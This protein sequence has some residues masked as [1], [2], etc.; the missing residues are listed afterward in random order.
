MKTHE[1]HTQTHTSTPHQPT[2]AKPFFGTQPDQ[3]F[4]ST[5]RAPATPFFQ[6]PAATNS[7]IQAKGATEEA[8]L[9]EPVVQRMPAFASEI[10][11][12]GAVQRSPW[13]SPPSLGSPIQ[14]KLTIGPVGDRYEQ[15]A[16]RVA[17]QVVEQIHA[18]AAAQSTPGQAV[19][20]Q[21]EEP[22]ELQAKPEITAL[23]RMEEKPEELQAKPE[24]TTIQ[25]MEEKPEELQAK[26]EITALQRMEEKPEE[27]QAKPEITALQRM[28]EKPEELQA[29]PEI[30]T[31]QRMEE[32]P[33]ELQAKSI[34][35]RQG[36]TSGEAAPD[37]TAAIDIARGSGQPLDMDLQRSIGQA[38]GADFSGVKVHTDAQSDQLNR[39]LQAKAFTTGQDVFFRQGAYEP[40]S[41]GGQELIA[42]ELTHVV[43]QNG[44]A[45]QQSPVLLQPLSRGRVSLQRKPVEDPKR[46][47]PFF[48]D[49][50]KPELKLKLTKDEESKKDFQIRNQLQPIYW[51]EETEDN[52]YKDVGRTEFFDVDA[53]LS[54]HRFGAWFE[55]YQE[56]RTEQAKIDEI[57]SEKMSEEE[58]TRRKNAISMYLMQEFIVNA[59]YRSEELTRMDYQASP[60]NLQEKSQYARSF[61]TSYTKALQDVVGK[62]YTPNKLLL[63]R[64]DDFN[65][66]LDKFFEVAQ[67][68]VEDPEASTIQSELA[69]TIEK[70]AEF[71]FTK[72][73][74]LEHYWEDPEDNKNTQ[75]FVDITPLLK[76]KTAEEQQ[77]ITDRLSRF[78]KKCFLKGVARKLAKLE[79][80]KQGKEAGGAF[81]QELSKKL[82][83]DVGVKQDEATKSKIW[84]QKEM[85]QN[86]ALADYILKDEN[87]KSFKDWLEK[88]DGKDQHETKCA[89]ALNKGEIEKARGFLLVFVRKVY[90]NWMKSESK[91]PEDITK[92]LTENRSEALADY[93]LEDKERRESFKTWL[94]ALPAKKLKQIHKDFAENLKA[95]NIDNAREQLITFVENFYPNW[96]DNRKV[97]PNNL[98]KDVSEAFTRLSG[99]VNKVS[100]S[101]NM[102]VVTGGMVGLETPSKDTQSAVL[103]DDATMDMAVKTAINK[104][105]NVP[106][107][108]DSL[109][110]LMKDKS[111]Q[112]IVVGVLT[113]Q[114]KKAGQSLKGEFE[115]LHTKITKFDPKAYQSLTQAVNQLEKTKEAFEAFKQQ[116]AEVKETET[117]EARAAIKLIEGSGALKEGVLPDFVLKQVQQH[118]EDAILNKTRI[119]DHVRSIQGLHEACILALE[120][121]S[122]EY[123][124]DF[125]YSAPEYKEEGEEKDSYFQ[126]AHITDYGLKAFAQTYDAVVAQVKQDGRDRVDITAF[127]NIYFELTDKLRATHAT[128]KGSKVEFETPSSASDFI[129][130]NRFEGISPSLKGPDVVF[131]DIHPNDATKKQIVSNDISFLIMGLFAKVKDPTTYRVTVMVDITLNHPG[132]D[133]VMAIRKHAQPYIKSGQLNLV[134]VQ[135][136]TK[137]AQLG[138]DKYSGGLVFAYNNPEKWKAFN[139]SITQARTKDQPDPTSHKYF[140]ALF[141]YC[142]EEQKEYLV[143]VRENTKQ[144]HLMLK[145]AFSKLNITSDAI[146]IAENSDDGSCYVAMRYDEFIAS[147]YPID[148][149]SDFNEVHHFNEDVL[150]HGINGLLQKL[151]L[152]VAMRFSFGFPVSNLGETGK[153]VRF[154]IGLEGKEQLQKYVDVISYINATLAKK[155]EELNITE[156]SSTK[157]KPLTE[158]KERQK[159]L[160]E[161]IAPIKTM[162]NLQSQLKDLLK[163]TL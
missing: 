42:H 153:E 3:A 34:L 37:L 48:Q 135:S 101:A 23:Q 47:K 67:V 155:F 85:E 146:Q 163:P 38:M 66:V 114:Q 35:Q 161:A 133:E 24:I 9:D 57:S 82:E 95:N 15:E 64:N 103:L 152:P 52:Y 65:L 4:F 18:P 156:T 87:R 77:K 99:R 142:A 70:S 88:K 112:D 27:L 136:L 92:K 36:Q 138:M 124:K 125:R 96:V 83:Q 79:T 105:G 115:A 143:R 151:G 81:E 159:F 29:K 62:G 131:V 44:A 20:R 19:Q 43:Q 97:N 13:H 11:A 162:E 21:E 158:G 137:F 108:S 74:D 154:T 12:E 63:T 139:D 106:P 107:P 89:D 150:E 110:K 145:E 116:F 25:R 22:E 160:Q 122:K 53:H 31:L 148:K 49:D 61:A 134:F 94:V 113:E 60:L 126:G 26:P 104:S 147:I 119:E 127:Y 121:N 14:A 132:E 123:D 40:G 130:S 100:S 120:L 68:K 2:A 86:R 72:D 17:A 91:N 55:T 102:A 8:D 7:T 41:R 58:K 76:G 109:R 117:L 1:T 59:L 144:V 69:T 141:T 93:I 33:E 5:E 128:S 73:R 30:T 129:H 50:K 157:F 149:A 32:K 90:G 84:N 39:S 46:K 56:A 16:D 54:T 45:V 71:V 111:L 80:E 28:E 98:E 10:P 6:P 140:Q 118:L 51:K 75:A 78:V